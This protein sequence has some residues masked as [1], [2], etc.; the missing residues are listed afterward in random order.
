MKPLHS[1][2]TINEVKSEDAIYYHLGKNIYKKRKKHSSAADHSFL[3][4]EDIRKKYHITKGNF[5]QGIIKFAKDTLYPIEDEK[6]EF[7]KRKDWDLKGICGQSKDVLLHPHFEK[8]R[9]II[10]EKHKKK[11][12]NLLILPCANKK[13]Y[14]DARMYSSIIRIFSCCCD[15]VYVSNPGLVPNEYCN[16]YPYRYYEWNDKELDDE[17]SKLYDKLVPKYIK[18]YL[19]HFNYDNIIVAILHYWERGVVDDIRD[20]GPESLS[21]KLIYPW[22]EKFIT[23]IIKNPDYNLT[24][25]LLYT[26]GYNFFPC[27]EKLYK[28]I[29]PTVKDKDE[30]KALQKAWKEHEENSASSYK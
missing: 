15:I 14:F 25:G 24:E 22:S 19:N 9:N 27:L 1:F 13:P 17:T 7:I 20:N 11:H 26:R 16:Y 5:R 4:R 6:N 18:D 28:D 3:S 8:I 29:L 21:K 23:G 12:N 2:I 30:R 10:K